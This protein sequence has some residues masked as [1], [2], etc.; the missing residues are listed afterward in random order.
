MILF[1]HV[2]WLS[3][4][5]PTHRVSLVWVLSLLVSG[6]VAQQTSGVSKIQGRVIEKI[7]PKVQGVAD[8]QVLISGQGLVSVD[9]NGYFTATVPNRTKLKIEVLPTT[10]QI[11]RPQDGQVSPERLSYTIEIYVLSGTI[12]SNLQVNLRK[13]DEEITR[14]T[15]Q[16]QLSDRQVSR[17]EKALLDTVLFYQGQKQVWDR[18]LEQ[19]EDQLEASTETNRRLRDSLRIFSGQIGILQ[20]TVSALMARLSAALEAKYLRQKEI[21]ETLTQEILDYE[22]RLKDL[23]N[24]LPK[25]QDCYRNN[26]ALYAF[27]DVCVAY[28]KARDAL[29][30]DQQT[31]L[32]GLQ[33]YWDNP[34]AVTA[35]ESYFQQVFSGI[36]DPIVMEQV[37]KVVIRNFQEYSNKGIRKA[38]ETRKAGDQAHDELSVQIPKLVAVQSHLFDILKQEI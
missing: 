19:V 9:Q 35:L 38:S 16:K 31:S 15:K 11:L 6:L 27:N 29:Y 28:S 36:H 8:A 25:V 37:N 24:W 33:H 4:V 21:Y 5:L 14:I 34:D 20:D 18:R 12:D 13:L 23:Q 3:K 32:L 7:G 22:S 26:Q 2:A 30:N 17:L 1:R 10:Y